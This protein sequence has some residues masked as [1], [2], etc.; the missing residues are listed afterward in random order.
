MFLALHFY[1]SE[2]CH[3]QALLHISGM[4]WDKF[5]EGNLRNEKESVCI[6]EHEIFSLIRLLYEFKS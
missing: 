3:A 1:S 6:Y 5:Y 4:L 2:C